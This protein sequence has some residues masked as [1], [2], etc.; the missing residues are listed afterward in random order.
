MKPFLFCGKDGGPDSTVWG[1]WLFE[2]KR[3]GSVA[4]LCFE[5]GSRDAFH[6][7][8]FDSVSW[9]LRGK[10]AEIQLEGGITRYTPSFRPILTRRATFH[11]VHSIGR[12]WV[13]TFRG[14]WAKTWQEYL[15]SGRFVTLSDGRRIN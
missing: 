15:P 10:L 14:P 12:T 13:L 11:K 1:V 3:L 5:H 2:L 9:V 7:H 4:L 6:S 8:A